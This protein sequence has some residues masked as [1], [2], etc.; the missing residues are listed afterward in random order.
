MCLYLLLNFVIRRS[1][2][3]SCGPSPGEQTWAQPLLPI[4]RMK[5][6]NALSSV[7]I[8]CETLVRYHSNQVGAWIKLTEKSLPLHPSPPPVSSSVTQKKRARVQIGVFYRYSAIAV[9]S[10][11]EH[12]PQGELELPERLHICVRFLRF[13]INSGYLLLVPIISACYLQHITGSLIVLYQI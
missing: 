10:L 13:W 6:N 8:E 11:S 4:S 1:K 12:I 2:S 3:G 5:S 7:Q 9:S